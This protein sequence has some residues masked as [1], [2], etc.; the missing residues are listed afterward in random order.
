MKKYKINELTIYSLVFPI[1]YFFC[2][3]E[4]W[5]KAVINTSGKP[6]PPSENTAWLLQTRA[7]R[8]RGAQAK[9]RE[10]SCARRT[11]VQH[12]GA[13]SQTLLSEGLN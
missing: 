11:R 2:S 1:Q 7:C 8:K 5:A 9:E 10:R 3:S 6:L 13:Q 4:A 12:P